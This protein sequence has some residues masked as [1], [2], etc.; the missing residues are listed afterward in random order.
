[1]LPASR[2]H[3]V[4]LQCGGWT[5]NWKAFGKKRSWSDW[6]TILT[7]VWIDWRKPRNTLVRIHAV[8]AE[9]Q[10]KDLPNTVQ[11]PRWLHFCWDLLQIQTDYSKG[12]HRTHDLTR[13]RERFITRVHYNMG[14]IGLRSCSSRFSSVLQYF[15]PCYA[16]ILSFLL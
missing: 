15:K 14:R 2:P 3:S 16:R 6:C 4:E 13:S 8:S 11:S 10:T 7:F 9:I 1:M 12:V 5:M